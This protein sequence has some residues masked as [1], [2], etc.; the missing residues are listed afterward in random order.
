MQS[1][2]SDGK[3]S[4]T[5]GAARKDSHSVT[6][7]LK[8]EL[9]TLMMSADQSVSAFPDNDNLFHWKG[10]ITGPSGTVRYML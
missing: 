2:A 6:K 3:M 5:H 4:E 9:M 1:A 10:T 7:R 8:Q